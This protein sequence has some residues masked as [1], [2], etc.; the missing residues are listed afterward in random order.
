MPGSLPR[1]SVKGSVAFTFNTEPRKRLPADGKG[2][3]QG[4]VNVSHP[5]QIICPCPPAGVFIR[6]TQIVSQRMFE[7]PAAGVLQVISPLSA[8]Q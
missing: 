8:Y 4:G 7:V 1:L 6:P 5:F 3:V 2:R